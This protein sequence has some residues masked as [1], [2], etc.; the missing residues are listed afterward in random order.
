MVT[1]SAAFTTTLKRLQDRFIHWKEF[2]WK[3]LQVKQRNAMGPNPITSQF[4]T[5][6]VSH[7]ATTPPLPLPSLVASVQGLAV[8]PW[9]WTWPLLAN[10]F[11]TQNEWPRCCWKGCRTTKDSTCCASERSFQYMYPSYSF[12]NVVVKVRKAIS[13]GLYSFKHMLAVAPALQ[14][15]GWL[16]CSVEV[17]HAVQVICFNTCTH[18]TAFSMWLWTLESNKHWVV[19]F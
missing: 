8:L 5:E 14:G 9:T 19:Q 17:W 3:W 10:S 12:F 18:P 15:V 1:A 16:T 11:G 2:C 4:R 7:C 6:R 13:L